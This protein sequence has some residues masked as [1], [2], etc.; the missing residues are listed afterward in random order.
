MK[1]GLRE[2]G[3][4]G[5]GM[6]QFYLKDI[7]L[8]NYRRFEQSTFELNRSM[9]V[10]VGKNGVG[11]TTILE[12]VNVMLGAYLA[13]F[14]KYV[15]SRF[16]FNIS[17]DDILLKNNQKAADNIV[18]SPVIPQYPCAISCHLQWGQE[19]L[20]YTRTVEKEGG[21]TKFAGTN[22]MQRKVEI[23]EWEIAKADGSDREVIL[24]LVDRKSVV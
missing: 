13:A 4:R 6:D 18:L 14:K 23:W 21:R 11:K 15:P 19:E 17:E 12:A 7:S 9:N 2:T 16:S 24:P 8:K 20:K 22:P 10:L 3:I 1:T 5:K